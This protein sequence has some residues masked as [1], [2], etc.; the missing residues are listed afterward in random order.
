[1]SVY[2]SEPESDS[3]P[4]S[5]AEVSE[6][7]PRSYDQVESVPLSVLLSLLLADATDPPATF[8]KSNDW[9]V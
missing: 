9:S 4:S 3:R 6:L 7:V 5:D 1:M 8:S 2:V